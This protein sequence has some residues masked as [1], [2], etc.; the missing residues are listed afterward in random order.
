MWGILYT[1][2]SITDD[3]DTHDYLEVNP[4]HRWLKQRVRR[5]HEFLRDTSDGETKATGNPACPCCNHGI[6]L[7][8]FSHTTRYTCIYSKS[9]TLCDQAHGRLLHLDSD[10]LT[11]H[12]LQMTYTYLLCLRIVHHYRS[13]EKTDWIR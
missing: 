12:V 3:A 9:I 2:C 5:L 6:V 10:A 8:A 11:H 4:H 13:G 7:D 1:A